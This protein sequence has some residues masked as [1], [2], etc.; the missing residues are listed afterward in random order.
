MLSEALNAGAA[1]VQVGTPFAYCAES[2]LDGEIKHKP[3]RRRGRGRCP[4][5][6]RSGRLATSFPFKVTVLE[7]SLSDPRSIAAAAACAISATCAQP[8][9]PP[10][11]ASATA[12]RPSPSPTYLAKGGKEENTVG[13]K[14]LCNALMANIGLS[15]IR[16][17]GLRGTRPGDIRQRPDWIDPLPAAARPLLHR[18][19]GRQPPAPRLPGTELDPA[20]VLVA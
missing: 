3:A 10:K 18:R 1:G 11:A 5:D 4:R 8:I 2:G 6:H 13:R 20:H 17:G 9:R 16:A 12:V 19:R 15:Q 14:C 7:D